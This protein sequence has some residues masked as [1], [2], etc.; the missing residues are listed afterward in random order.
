V[1]V[2]LVAVGLVPMAYEQIGQWP[3]SSADAGATQRAAQQNTAIIEQTHGTVQRYRA[4][5]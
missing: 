1:A 2:F 4:K 3:K 5:I